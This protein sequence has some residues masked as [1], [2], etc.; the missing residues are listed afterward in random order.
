MSNNLSLFLLLSISSVFLAASVHYN[1][2]LLY[3]H[4]T[5]ATINATVIVTHDKER[6]SPHRVEDLSEGLNVI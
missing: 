5:R 2:K 3:D 4:T 1:I 6:E